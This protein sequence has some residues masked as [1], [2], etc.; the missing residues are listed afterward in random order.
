MFK[1]IFS[2]IKSFGKKVVSKIV[3]FVG[4]TIGIQPQVIES[5]VPPQTEQVADNKTEEGF[6]KQALKATKKAFSKAIKVVFTFIKIH[7]IDSGIS[8][9]II[10]ICDNTIINT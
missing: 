6:V 9:Y 8:W 5:A 10:S 3:A 2:N 4:G 1:S 7:I